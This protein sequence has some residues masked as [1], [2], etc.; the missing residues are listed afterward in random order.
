MQDLEYDIVCKINFEKPKGKEK[1]DKE[2]KRKFRN[3]MKPLLVDFDT[4]ESLSNCDRTCDDFCSNHGPGIA[5]TEIFIPG[6]PIIQ[7]VRND[8]RLKLK[9][10]PHYS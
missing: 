8:K 5:R 2:N 4:F 7:K 6:A 10:C 1:I 9:N 3:L